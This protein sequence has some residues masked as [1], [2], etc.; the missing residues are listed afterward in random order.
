MEFTLLWQAGTGVVAALLVARLQLK[1][2]LVGQN[3]AL[4]D[5]LVAAAATGMLIGRLTSMILQGVNPLLSPADILVVR[6][7]VHTGA[8]SVAASVTLGWALRR[9]LWRNLDAAA[10]TALPGLAGWHAGCLFRSACLG[11]VSNLPWAFPQPGS[12]ISRHPVELYAARLFLLG[13]VTALW[14]GHRRR[15]GVLTGMTMTVAALIRLG[16]Q[17]FR[18]TITGGPVEWYAAG[19][20]LGVAVAIFSWRWGTEQVTENS[21]ESTSS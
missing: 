5:A 6:G 14:V 13:A 10:P 9:A 3:V 15:A 11:T 2:G 1:R 16:T 20:L 8:A 21:E 4:G 19:V 7:G 12:D 18:P 17:P